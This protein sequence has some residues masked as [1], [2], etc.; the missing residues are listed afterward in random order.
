[1]IP[2][3]SSGPRA[4]STSSSKFW[5]FFS[6]RK[7][8]CPR[9]LFTSVSEPLT[10]CMAQHTHLCYLNARQPK[11]RKRWTLRKDRH[12]RYALFSK[13]KAVESELPPKPLSTPLMPIHRSWS[14]TFS[15][16]LTRPFALFA[17]EPIAQLLGLYIALVY[18]IFYRAFP[19]LYPPQHSLTPFFISSS[20]PDKHARN[21]RG[22]LPRDDGHRGAALYCAR[23]RA[24]SRVAAQR[25]V[26]GPRICALQAQEQRCWRA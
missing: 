23:H 15:K 20:V 14:Q 22:L 6:Y 11:S 26:H 2:V 3:H 19:S 17:R 18:G 4:S 10:Q 7:V 25:A 8:R 16:T 9:K 5:G 1:M 24:H 21:L 13:S 12:G